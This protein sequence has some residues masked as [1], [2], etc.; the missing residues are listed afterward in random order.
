[1][2]KRKNK[3]LL[4]SADLRPI[5]HLGQNFLVSEEIIKKIIKAA[6]IKKGAT[7]LEV[8]SGTGNLTKALLESGARVI[9]VEKDDKLVHLL[10]SNFQ[11]LISKQNPNLKLQIINKDILSFDENSINPPYRVIANI[12]YYL[13]G[14]LIQKFL[15]S[16][17][18]PSELMLMVQKEVG[19]RITAQ[20][21]R[22]NYLSSLV[23]FLAETEILFHVKKE[24]FWP[25]P[26]V[27]S[28]IIKLTPRL[29]P[30]IPSLRSQA[31][32]TFDAEMKSGASANFLQFLKMVF[33]QPRQTLFNNLRKSGV[34]LPDKLDATLK[35]LKL[36][37]K[38]RP[39][40]LDTQQ[41]LKLFRTIF[42]C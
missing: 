10:I 29:H 37:K 34:S 25:Q 8:G 39:Q 18:K 20:P 9:A 16:K 2:L 42:G 32:Y 26:K 6:A 17:N 13:T 19:E 35:E 23:Q 4:K 30:C 38:I 15:L 40:N 24:N 31:R 14:A 41:L 27:D 11:Y 1:M 3:L 21:P 5:K 28:V 12:P 36:D 7:I 33:R 22:A